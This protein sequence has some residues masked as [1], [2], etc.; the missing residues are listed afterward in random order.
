MCLFFFTL[1]FIII[2]FVESLALKALYFV[3]CFW[4]P[5]ECWHFENMVIFR[6]S[7]CFKM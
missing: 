2:I 5:V 3:L 4:D 1:W 7:S 6:F